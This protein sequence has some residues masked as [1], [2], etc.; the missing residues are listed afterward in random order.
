MLVPIDSIRLDG[1]TQPR[2]KIREPAVARYAE[3]MKAGAS[4]PPV[5]VFFDGKDRWLADG[6]HRVHAARKAGRAEIE[7]EQ[8][9]G[10][11][12]DAVLYAVGANDGHGLPRTNADKWEAVKTVLGDKEWRKWSDH[13]IG[14]ACRVTHSFVGRVR[15]SLGTVTS[16]TRKYRTRNGR[17]A[18]MNTARIGKKRGKRAA[19]PVNGKAPV[20]RAD[21][22]P[23][24]QQIAKEVMRQF[25]LDE[26]RLIV[27]ELERLIEE[28][29]GKT[30]R[31]A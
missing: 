25:P 1:G 16:G 6:F 13:E 14:R 10:T 2:A 24:H 15:R 7:A 30:T 28:A 19:R 26:V 11:R 17:T 22:V 12:R 4:F 29:A 3:A 9:T 5:V 20:G 23:L 18:T 31:P 27:A 21:D 8:R